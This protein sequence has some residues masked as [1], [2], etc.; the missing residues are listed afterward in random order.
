MAI[1]PWPQLTDVARYVINA[2]REA[3]VESPQRLVYVSV[4]TA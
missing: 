1:F 2:A 3:K 4:R